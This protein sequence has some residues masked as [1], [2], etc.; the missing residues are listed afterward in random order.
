MGM[1]LA[2][3]PNR[4]DMEPEVITSCSQVGL[5]VERG[6]HQPT[7]KTFDPKFVLPTRSRDRD[8]AETKEM[9]N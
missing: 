7:H 3:V 8:R 2:E 5:L 9:A 4:G 6:G 1:T